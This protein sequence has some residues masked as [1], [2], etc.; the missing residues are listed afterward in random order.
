MALPLGHFRLPGNTPVEASFKIWQCSINSFFRLFLYQ[1]C[2][3]MKEQQSEEFLIILLYSTFRIL[4][5][6]DI[7]DIQDGAF[8]GLDDLFEM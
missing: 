5:D 2:R 4:A 1:F 7:T 8:D 6:N 3:H